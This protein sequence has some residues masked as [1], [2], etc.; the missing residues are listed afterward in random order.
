MA[1]PFVSAIP[2]KF[3]ENFWMEC[4]G[5]LV[6]APPVISAWWDH[7]IYHYNEPQRAYHTV[8]HL[9]EMVGGLNH[10]SMESLISR[11]ELVGLA[12]FFHDIIY[13]PKAS[14]NEEQSAVVFKKFA[15]DAT[16]SRQ[17]TLHPADVAFVEEAIMATKS[18][19]HCREDGDMDALLD[20]DLAILGAPRQRYMEYARQIRQEYAHVAPL[21]F[22]RGRTGVLRSFMDSPRI[23][24][25]ELLRSMLEATAR[26]NMSAEVA[27]L[28]G[29]D[30][31]LCRLTICD[32]PSLLAFEASHME[33]SQRLSED[34]MTHA[35]ALNYHECL[36]YRDDQD[37]IVA[38][39]VS[40]RA[41]TETERRYHDSQ[42]I[43][44]VLLQIGTHPSVRRRG[45]GS[46]LIREYLDV[47]YA[48][49]PQAVTLTCTDVIAPLFASVGFVA[50]EKG[51]NATVSMRLDI[52][53]K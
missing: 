30:Y 45:V 49:P 3:L 6:I 18:H 39:I 20:L 4:C 34:V 31:R 35:I 24:R 50:S 47:L 7:V 36:G 22:V 28:K 17:C 41:K 11:R 42:G 19:R 44:G 16:A 14:D 38:Y 29:S 27:A 52:T 2:L 33:P 32:V 40:I 21:D 9:Q 46:A 15:M 37:S 51:A 25:T 1:E 10:T 43:F 8:N 5:R 12:I 13:D 26:R 23:Y 53:D 48:H